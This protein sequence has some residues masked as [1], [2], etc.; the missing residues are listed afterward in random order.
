MRDEWALLVSESLHTLPAVLSDE[1]H[2][3]HRGDLHLLQLVPAPGEHVKSLLFPVAEWNKNSTALRQLLVVSRRYFRRARADEYRIVR[4][5]L[6]PAQSAIAKKKGDVAR[7]DLPES[8][9]V[10]CRATPE[11]AR[12]RR[13]AR[14]AATAARSDNPSRFRSPELSRSRSASEA[15]GSERGSTAAK[16]SDRC[17]SEA[18]NPR[19]RGVERPSGR[20]GGAASGR[21][22]EDGEVPDALVVQQLHEPAARPAKLVL[23]GCCHHVSAAASMA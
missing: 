2:E 12:S 8:S 15:R 16:S 23:Y 14:R 3:P 9:R 17:R 6:S 13:P 20:R 21:W 1:W 4:S 22:R 18:P 11:F 5:V 19:T 7:A 10:R